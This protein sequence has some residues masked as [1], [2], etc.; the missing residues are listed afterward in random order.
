MSDSLWPY[1]LYSPWNSPSQN[2]G[3]GS[4]SLLQGIFPTQGLN[5]GLLHCRRILHQLSHKGSP[6]FLGH[7]HLPPGPLNGLP[8]PL[9]LLPWLHYPQPSQTAFPNINLMENHLWL[10]F[11]LNMKMI[12]SPPWQEE[13]LAPASLLLPHGVC[14][15]LQPHWLYNNG[16][17]VDSPL[18]PLFI[19]L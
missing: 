14:P 10:P 6:F 4:L 9:G 12:P 3:M 13:G 1:G 5:P 18:F 19:H 7:T 2:T 8:G 11:V 17:P 15:E 16:R